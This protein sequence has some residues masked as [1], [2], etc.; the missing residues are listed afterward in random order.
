MRKARRPFFFPLCLFSSLS[1]P[2]SHLHPHLGV[3]LSL[4]L[5]LSPPSF[6]GLQDQAFFWFSQSPACRKTPL[7]ANIAV[8]FRITK[9]QQLCKQNITGIMNP[10]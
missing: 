8:G 3:C 1:H 6:L 2:H 7:E 10:L 9:G 4:S 5:S